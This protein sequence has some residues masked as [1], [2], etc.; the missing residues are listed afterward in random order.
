[1]R[2]SE[3]WLHSR[4]IRLSVSRETYGQTPMAKVDYLRLHHLCGRGSSHQQIAI[5]AAAFRFAILAE[6]KTVFLATLV[7]GD[8][9]NPLN[10]DVASMPTCRLTSVPL[11]GLGIAC[12]DVEA[13]TGA[14]GAAPLSQNV[15]QTHI[16]QSTYGRKHLQHQH[17][18]QVQIKERR[19]GDSN[20]RSGCPD[21]TF[22]VLHNRPLCHLSE[23]HPS[24]EDIFT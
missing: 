11:L 19:E 21:T 10:F 20:P 7:D 4:G 13:P 8:G 17:L 22:P 1:M 18:Q 16:V 9:A 2:V 3:R 15:S 23:R 6:I 12:Y 14:T 24:R 5:N